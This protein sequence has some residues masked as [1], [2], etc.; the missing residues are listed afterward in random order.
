MMMLSDSFITDET[1]HFPVSPAKYS[2]EITPL[3]GRFSGYL[4]DLLDQMLILPEEWDELDYFSRMKIFAAETESELLELLRSL[5]LLTAFQADMIRK[6]CAKYLMIGQYRVLDLIGRGGMGVV[7]RAENTHLRREVA[8]KVFSNSLSTCPRLIRRFHAEARA[9]ARLQHPHLVNCL[10]AGRHRTTDPTD[11]VFD[12]YIMDLVNGQNLD[13][14]VRLH[15]PLPV[16]RACELFRQVAD[17]LAEAHRHGLVHR[18]IKPHN[19]LVTPDWQAKV[20]DFGLALHP[21]ERMTDPGTMLGTI[22]FM[23]PEQAQDP[24]A[25]DARADIFGLGA[26]LYWALTGK[27]PF[28]DSGN[29]LRDLQTRLTSN[30]LVIQKTKTDL[31]EE[32]STLLN[33]MLSNDPES[34]PQSARV[35]AI[36]L[37]GLSRSIPQ[38]EARQ[39]LDTGLPGAPSILLVEDDST[40]RLL[41]R[42]Y[43]GDEFLIQEAED[44]TSLMTQLQKQ[45]PDLI[46]LDVNLPGSIGYELIDSIRA[47]CPEDRRP[48]I[49]LT[50]GVIPPEFLG[51]LTTTGADDFLAKPFNRV[52]F[53]SRIRGLLGRK[54][55]LPKTI[56]ASRVGSVLMKLPGASLAALSLQRTSVTQPSSE[57][58]SLLTGVFSQMLHETMSFG[59]AYGE[60][61]GKY[62][63]ALV[64]ALP[65]CDEYR[66]LKEEEYL[67]LLVSVAPLHDIG[68]IA[69][70]ASIL[71]KPSSLDAQERLVVQTHPVMG[72]DWLTTASLRH[73]EALE[74]LTLAAEIVRS[75]HER[76]DGKGY[77]DG[78]MED[79]TPLPARVVGLAA[80]YDALRSRRVYRPGLSHARVIRMLLNEVT[81]QFDPAL[82]QA[83]GESST[84]F[85]K[86]F[87]TSRD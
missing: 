57:P 21:Q 48:M 19:I 13:S 12:Y 44:S 35:V 69:L 22:G 56:G 7:Y 53:R 63:R 65:E 67:S 81:G 86:I 9:A 40:I 47:F 79:E 46:V 77:P 15:G 31:P 83:L 30:T 62:I 87:Q 72:Y 11:P 32:L 43:L 8:M 54:K 68:M 28:P 23:A 24:Q 82:L 75:H 38:N 85:E 70:P 39:K 61:L 17:A 51:G 74:P 76:W 49:L 2:Q 33:R 66:E 26:S 52:D 16:S 20:L 4:N 73:P 3:E 25:V 71:R 55:Y 29:P 34:R 36:T 78:L 42:A 18:D 50:S 45:I 5:H 80:T 84:Q 6:G 1:M 10:D 41:M 60:R 58:I 37:A 27:E 64:A 59:T 14:L